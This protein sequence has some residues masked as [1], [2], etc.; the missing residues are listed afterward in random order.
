MSPS[1]AAL[2]RQVLEAADNDPNVNNAHTEQNFAT[3]YREFLACSCTPEDT[4]YLVDD[5]NNCVKPHRI[6]VQYFFYT[7]REFNSFIPLMPG[8]MAS[9]T[10]D[11]MK[12][13]FHKAMPAK[14]RERF[15][16][17]GKNDKYFEN[18]INLRDQGLPSKREARP[19]ISLQRVSQRHNTS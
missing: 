6:P 3:R 15:T 19:T 7:L 5:I 11:Q 8:N 2:W 10:V 16:D 4:Q 9:L 12:T 1:M 13:A 17:A 14:W 18:T